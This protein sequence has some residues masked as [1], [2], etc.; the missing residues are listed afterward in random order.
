MVKIVLKRGYIGIP[1]KQKKVLRAL[2]LK[3]IGSAVTKKDDEA[4]RGMINAVSHL[5]EVQ[6]V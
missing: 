2:G 3:K 4:I 6:E 5:I 1:D